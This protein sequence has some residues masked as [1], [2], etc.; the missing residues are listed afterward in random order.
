MMDGNSST[1]SKFGLKAAS[2]REALLHGGRV[3]KYKGIAGGIAPHSIG[4]TSAFATAALAFGGVMFSATPAFAG[5]C[6]FDGTTYLCSG[7]AGA[8]GTDAPVAIN[9][10]GTTTV[11][12]EPGFGI[13]ANA[14]LGAITITGTGTGDITFTDVNQSAITSQGN[15]GIRVYSQ[16]TGAVSIDTNGVL[17]SVSTGVAVH[18]GVDT[19]DV[20]VKVNDVNAGD[21]G[22]HLLNNLGTGDI[23]ITAHDIDAGATGIIFDASPF[24]GDFTVDVN[25]ITAGLDGIYGFASGDGDVDI[26]VHD[27][28][29]ADRNGIWMDVDTDGPSKVSINVNNIEAGNEGINLDTSVSTTDLNIEVNDVTSQASAIHFVH[30]GTGTTTVT[31]NDIKSTNGHGLWFETH[32]TDTLVTVH[33]INT[34][35]IGMWIDHAGSGSATLIAHDIES[36]GNE[37]INIETFVPSTDLNIEVN[38]ITSQASGIHFVHRGSGDTIIT[39]NDITSE[40]GLGIW[41]TTYG[42]GDTAITAHNIDAAGEGI[43]VDVAGANN[44]TDNN[45]SIAVNDVTA[46]ASGIR[47]NAFN[48][49]NVSVAANDIDAGFIGIWF[50][51]A[52]S[53]NDFTVTANNITAG[54]DGINGFASGTGATS[55]TVAGSIVSGDDGIELYADNADA[56]TVS[57]D[58]NNVKGADNAIYVG[59]SSAALADPTLNAL[60]VTTRGHIEAGSGWGIW[61]QTNAGVMSNITVKDGSVIEASSGAAIGNNGG[62]SH[63]V[64]ENAKEIV[65]DPNTPGV[66]KSSVNGRI[67]LGG[68][69]DILDLHGGFSGITRVDGGGQAGDTLNLDKAKST[70]DASKIVGWDVFNIEDS[71]LTLEGGLANLNVGRN[72]VAGT[73]IFLTDGSTLESRQR[74]LNINGNLTLA[75]G[76]TFI[77]D[78]NDDAGNPGRGDTVISGFLHNAG[79]VSLRD[80]AADDIL[81]VNGAYVGN[82][83]TFQIETVLG[84]DQ[85]KTDQLQFFGG[86]SGTSKIVVTN[87]GGTGAPTVE[88]IKVVDVRGASDGTFTL[89]GDYE[90]AGQQAIV[91]GAYAYTLQKN[92]VSNSTDGDWYLRSS[93]APVDSGNPG[94]GGPGTGEPGTGEPGTGGPIEPEPLCIPGVPIYEA[95]GANLQALNGLATL[96]QRVG[97]RSWATGAGIAGGGVWGRVEGT[98]NRANPG[99]SSSG[100]DQKINSWKMQ[101]GADHV[102]ISAENGGQLVAGLNAYYG[103]AESHIRSLSGNG[104]LE[105]DGYGFGASLTWYGLNGF[106]VDG[107]AQVSWYNS[108]LTSDIFGKLA[109]GNDGS[110]EAFSLEIGK[111]ASIGGKLSVTPQVQ[112]I[113][114]NVRFDGLLDP[115][116]ASVKSDK[117]DSLRTRWGL[118]LDRQSEW[119]QGRSH[120]YGLINLNYEWLDGTRAVV[121][122]TDIDNANYRFWGELG[123]GGSISWGQGVTLYAEVSGSS[124]FKD[125]GDSYVLKGNAGLRVAF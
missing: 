63:V 30:R 72:G 70:Y 18:M 109:D 67:D 106:Y 54:D 28:I 5:D 34:A 103:Q 99:V 76:T 36:S 61:T 89:V 62:D 65:D 47:F 82:N 46:G 116:G 122:G 83:G 13:D 6:T 43:Y 91:A 40:S 78:R 11:T 25:K 94:T 39:A 44:V 45:Y 115:T 42:L 85:S 112:M 68:G 86:T 71:Y 1:I 69:V 96:Q 19:T 3:G 97:N 104:L 66:E 16:N 119:E 102:L 57:F 12:T 2:W 4:A 110:G 22:V 101:V 14:S 56:K 58:V 81:T 60:N 74:G 111:R 124:P 38:D 98:R 84:D 80:N 51:N 118:S 7:A 21:H 123:L 23:S 55:V 64:I 108:D 10:N 53:T 93:L 15:V 35:G 9:H 37:G 105:T 120:I 117:G 33:D 125:F 107:Q 26:T 29:V 48:T 52:T 88:G 87:L 20:T 92:G 95:Y 77:S 50:D 8:P 73:G 90:I 32:G 114:S 27:S 17:T 100:L 75:A 59:S 41:G 24:S 79:T 31:A 113:Y 49:G 121:A